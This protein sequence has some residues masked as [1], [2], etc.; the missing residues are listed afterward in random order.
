LERHLSDSFGVYSRS[1]DF[2]VRIR[3]NR[4]VA[5]YIREKRWHPSQV[6]VELPDQGVEL[7][8]RLGSLEEISRW[9]LGWGAH[10]TVLSPPELVSIL[11][12]TAQALVKN[13]PMS[14]KP[15]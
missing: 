6:L 1:G 7:Q 14:P 13:Y 12:E 2:E 15:G 11:R 3:F 8:L 9:I 4:A 5:D 10:A